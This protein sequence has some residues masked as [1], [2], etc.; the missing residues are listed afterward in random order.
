M[1]LV[2]LCMLGLVTVKASVLRTKFHNNGRTRIAASDYC[3]RTYYQGYLAPWQEIVNNRTG[4]LQIWDG[5]SYKLSPPITILGCTND[6]GS[7]QHTIPATLHWSKAAAQCHGMCLTNV[8]A[9]RGTDCHCLGESYIPANDVDC[10]PMIA[11]S[12]A[13]NSKNEDAK[14]VFKTVSVDIE[15]PSSDRCLAQNNTNGCNFEFRRCS[16]S[17]RMMCKAGTSVP[18]SWE[19]AAYGCTSANSFPRPV[20]DVCIPGTAGNIE[21]YGGFRLLQ[22]IPGSTDGTFCKRL[23]YSN[24]YATPTFKEVSCD[25]SFRFYCRYTGKSY[26]ERCDVSISNVCQD[27]LSC[28]STDAESKCR[29]SGDMV[30]NPAS[31]SCQTRRTYNQGCFD[32]IPGFCVDGLSCQSSDGNFKCLCS[33]NEYFDAKSSMTC[34]LRKTYAESCDSSIHNVCDDSLSCLSKEGSFQCVCNTTLYLDQGT[35]QCVPRKSYG[36]G[37]DN[38]IDEVCEEKMTCESRAGLYLCGCDSQHYWDGASLQCLPL[39]SYRGDCLEDTQCSPGL[40]C[41]VTSSE[42]N[43]KCICVTGSYWD[44]TVSCIIKHG[45]NQTCPPRISNS[46]KSNLICKS[47]EVK[48]GC[49]DN[50]YY[51][52]ISQD[53]LEKEMYNNTCSPGPDNPCQGDLRCLGFGD[54]HPLSL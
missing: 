42:S 6:T 32:G 48:C 54:G 27:G 1:E 20:P 14:T 44:R 21:W 37:C 17:L 36:Q 13:L 51:E 43:K 25:S 50:E 33:S 40:T 16:D 26:D 15:G 39:I 45:Y 18:A 49:P 12:T 28:Q 29:C 30:W 53:C 7:S 9:I 38:L 34:I 31:R 23:S 2:F 46:C 19:E 24:Q 41:N 52:E 5:N 3:E 4:S 8:F 22:Y 11:R 10:L 47:D 35:R